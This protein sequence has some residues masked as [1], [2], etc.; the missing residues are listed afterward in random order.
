VSAQATVKKNGA[1]MLDGV[2]IGT[3]EKVESCKTGF[4][5]GYCIGQVPC[6][7]Y[8]A[9]ASD[10]KRINTT[11]LGGYSVGWERRADAVAA[12]VKH[13]EKVVQP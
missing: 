8:E 1:V 5:R 11:V 9:T 6:M 7:R 12:L 2:Q 4:R 10:G 3:I 13:Y